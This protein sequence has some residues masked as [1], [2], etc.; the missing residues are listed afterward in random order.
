MPGVPY[1]LKKLA[2]LR[3]DLWAGFSEPSEQFPQVEQVFLEYDANHDDVVQ[4][5][6]T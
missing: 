2:L 1:V 3:I 6:E 5:Y 4:V